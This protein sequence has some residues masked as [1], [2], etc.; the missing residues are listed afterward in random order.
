VTGVGELVRS[1]RDAGV[2]T[3]TLDSQHNRNALSRQLVSELQGCLDE[4]GDARAIVLAHAGPVFCS[5]ADL[6]ERADT[7]VPID[8]RPV[9]TVM[10]TLS[11][12][13]CPTIAAV[14]GS[15]RAGG[16]G[17]MAACDLVVVSGGVSFALT[18]VRIGV[19]PAVISVPIL[20]RVPAGKIAAAMLTGQPFGA[21]EALA[22]GLVTHVTDDVDATVAELCAAIAAGAPGAIADTKRLLRDVPLLDRTT[23]FAA[24]SELSDRLFRSPEGAE[25]MAAFA[26]KR[27]PVW[28]VS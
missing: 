21:V 19:A 17:L 15:V 7:S 8:S 10:E 13:G 6:K 24:M 1:E 23:A 4:A 11:D 3:I 20:R 18:E 27:P 28:P 12:V 14:G 25:G 16:L 9:V 5:G 26:A 2:V 22:M